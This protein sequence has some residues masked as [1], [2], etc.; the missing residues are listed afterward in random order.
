MQHKY[1][2]AWF[3][4][5]DMIFIEE[6]FNPTKSMTTIRLEKVDIRIVSTMQN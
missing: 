2:Y 5:V 3:H 1:K 6:L 4:Q